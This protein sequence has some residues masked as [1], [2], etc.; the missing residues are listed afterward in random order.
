MRKHVIEAKDSESDPCQA[1]NGNLGA[2]HS[3]PHNRNRPDD[4]EKDDRHH[5]ENDERTDS[6][7]NVFAVHGMQ[8]NFWYVH[9][10]FRVLRED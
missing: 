1:W 6:E 4:Q 9:K 7:T 2:D 8:E 10:K 3:R 5:S